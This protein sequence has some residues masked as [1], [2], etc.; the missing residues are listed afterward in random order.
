MILAIQMGLALLGPL[1]DGLLKSSA[2]KQVIDAVSAAI[3]ALEAHK[4]DLIT[5]AALEAQRG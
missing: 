3:T 1:L 4:N 5:K 2:P